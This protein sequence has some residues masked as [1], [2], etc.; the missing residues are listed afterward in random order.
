LTIRRGDDIMQVMATSRSRGQQIA[1]ALLIAVTLLLAAALLA[2]TSTSTSSASAIS[3]SSA[4]A[5][6]AAAPG[7]HPASHAKTR[8]ARIRH[9]CRRPTPKHPECLALGRV[10]VAPGTVGARP[11]VQNDGA[12][13]SGPAGGLTPA[14]LASAYE[15][16][17]AEGGAGQTVALVDAYDD[18]NIEKDLATFDTNYGLPACTSA[19]G[20][21]TK[22]S[23]TGSTTSLPKA[24]KEG[25]SVEITL[26]VESAHAVCESCKILLVEANESTNAA[27]A[28]AVDEAATLGAT[29]ISN[30]YGGIEEAGEEA[31]YNHPG[32]VI[33]ASA[34]D[35]G[36]YGWDEL[37]KNKSLPLPEK[38]AIPAALPTVVAVGGTSLYLNENGTRN[39]ETV[40]NNNGP[41]DEVG[42]REK[43]A[44]GATGGGCSTLFTSQPWQQ[45]IPPARVEAKT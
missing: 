36:Y 37:N 43:A 34:G 6:R 31:A 27:L 19:N 18:P 15:Y 16:D 20:C 14:Q 10:T 32:V 9:A 24:D 4:S 40:W 3:T 7:S 11:F 17:P 28:T 2:G 42:L 23:Q 25:W 41:G 21:F 12:T 29:E 35:E 5:A 22:V 30:S 13:E 38:L 45:D 1:V 39:S 26:D 33:T 44:M 8:Y